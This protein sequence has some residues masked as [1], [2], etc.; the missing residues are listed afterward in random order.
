VT[1]DVDSYNQT[2]AQNRP[3]EREKLGK[4]LVTA[5]TSNPNSKR[6][7]DH[8][9][10]RKRAMESLPSSTNPPVIIDPFGVPLCRG[11]LITPLPSNNLNLIAA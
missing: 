1:E 5:G 3:T 11:A 7:A 2:V 6:R 8:R 4:A 9:E 10:N